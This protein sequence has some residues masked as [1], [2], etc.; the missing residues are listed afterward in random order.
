MGLGSA[1]VMLDEERRE[2]EPCYGA[3]SKV[4]VFSF[5]AALFAA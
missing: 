5:V 2:E 3:D 4:I 1:L